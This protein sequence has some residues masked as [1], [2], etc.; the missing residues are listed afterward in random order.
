MKCSPLRWLWGLVPLALLWWIALMG[1]Q[2]RIQDDLSLRAKGVLEQAGLP[3]ATAT[4]TARDVLVGGRAEEESEQ[5]RAAIEV[6]KV[7]G[8]RSLE[9]RTEVLE[10]IKNYT[11]SAA[12]RNGILALTG[13][14][15]NEAARKAVLAS[16]RSAFPKHKVDDQLKLA[17]GAPEQKQWLGGTGFALRQLAQL[18]SGGRAVL[19]GAGLVIE[20]EAESSKSYETVRTALTGAL[21]Q[22]ISLKA[23][24]VTPPLVRP[25]TWA[26][27]LRGRQIELTGYAP[28][29]LVRDQ[30]KAAAER[31]LPG[32]A[33]A[34]R[35][36]IGAGAPA[37]W[38]KVVSA[39]L[40]RLGQL[41]EGHA[42]IRDSQLTIA[43]LTETEAAADDIRRALRSEIPVAFR[44]DEQIH[45]D[46]AV[47]AAEEARRR[48]AEEAAR[49]AAAEAEA[50]RVAE[51][52][53]QQV[54]EQSRA[55]AAEDAARRAAED[56]AR[57][58]AEE[59]ARLAAEDA[60]RRKAEADARRAAD[61][62]A[63][64]RVEAEEGAR[65]AAAAAEGRR[66]AEEDRA[67]A[68]AATAA[69]APAVPAP[70]PTRS[71]EAQ[72]CQ[73]SL[74]AATDAGTITFQRASAELDRRSHQ[75]LNA[76]AQIVRSCPSYV[77]EIAGHTDNE[78][79]PD[80]NKRL[81]DRRARSV[82][83]YLVKAGVPQQMLTA[84]GYGEDKPIVANDTPANMARNRR[85]EFRVKAR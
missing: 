59:D 21:P 22:G 32:A 10:L 65:R 19:D 11:W 51:L 81:S 34:N 7:W 29:V 45:Q 75:T 76:L 78:G 68:V 43:G 3:W 80:R 23:D 63:R 52:Q 49:R 37:D 77:I 57:R 35:L 9:D 44:I 72:R 18:N 69:A 56:A 73:A 33:V 54:E 4:F 24:K 39:A 61:E 79:E 74:T 48:A 64:Q 14:V 31:A 67:R 40:V 6:A 38:Q 55:R 46:P 41:K 58:K 71:A 28:S 30:L 2:S 5:R 84:E 60:A 16:A 50:R 13:Y 1:N 85:I 62:A 20:G 27:T 83:D 53:R 36:A 15:P 42:Q 70:V 26:A 47:K 8:V 17:R 82:Q 12:S 66:K 25:Y